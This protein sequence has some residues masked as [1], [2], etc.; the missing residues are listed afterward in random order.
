M[1]YGLSR[2]VLMF[3]LYAI[4]DQPY[5]TSGTRLPSY[6]VTL[7]FLTRQGWERWGGAPLIGSMASLA[8]SRL[9]LAPFD[10]K[11]S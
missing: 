8:M 1:A 10:P 11:A 3:Q 9:T 7:S 6:A 4:S 5:A 2:M